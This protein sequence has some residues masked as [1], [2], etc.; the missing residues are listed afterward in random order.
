MQAFPGQLTTHGGHGCQAI[1]WH[2]APFYLRVYF[3]VN[4]IRYSIFPVTDA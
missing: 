2:I 4:M 3:V 1:V